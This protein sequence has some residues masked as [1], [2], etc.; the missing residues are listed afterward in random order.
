MVMSIKPAAH[1][2]GGG[3]KEIGG[4]ATATLLT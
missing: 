3:V 4:G 1:D 2:D